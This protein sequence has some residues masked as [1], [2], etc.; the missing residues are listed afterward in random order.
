[1]S[2]DQGS[3]KNPNNFNNN[4]SK[5]TFNKLRN[6][7]GTS[8]FGKT[9]AIENQSQSSITESLEPETTTTEQPSKIDSFFQANDT[10]QVETNNSCSLY[11]GAYVPELS[12][13]QYVIRQDKLNDIQ[14]FVVKDSKTQVIII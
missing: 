1:M 14:R 7:I 11:Q 8:F 3:L 2:I 13:N 6:F 10:N 9:K 5:T 4:N 12:R